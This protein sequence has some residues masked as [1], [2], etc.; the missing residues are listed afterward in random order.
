M[1]WRRGTSGVV[2]S[3]TDATGYG[4][5]TMLGGTEESAGEMEKQLMRMGKGGVAEPCH[6][7]LPVLA[8]WHVAV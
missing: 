7:P 4:T 1:W 8:P 6:E 5:T 3:A 2:R